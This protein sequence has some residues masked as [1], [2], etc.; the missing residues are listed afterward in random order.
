M[1]AALP[2]R[3]VRL[4]AVLATLVVSASYAYAQFGGG[5]FRGGFLVGEQGDP[6]EIMAGPRE[7]ADFTACH[8]L[9]TSVRREANGAGWRTDYPW[10]ERHLLLRLSELTKT[11]VSWLS[12]NVPHSWLVALTDDAL[13][14]CSYVTASDVG[15]IELSPEEAARLR[16]Y[17]EK[18]GFLWVDDFWGEAAW[19]QWASELGKAMPPDEFPIEEVALSD[20]IFHV[21]TEVTAVP[22]VPSIR[23]WRGSGGGTSE[24]GA[25]SAVPRLK[26]I[27][28]THQRIVVV[29]T[30]NTDMSDSFE[31]EGEDPRFF[32]QFSPNGYA[33]GINVLLY[34]LTH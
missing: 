18:G 23:F 29:M 15:T 27:R 4:F 12:K 11:R 24:R 31:R 25:E 20:P 22:Q 16:L 7:D 2:R 13:F 21:M 9:Y 33:L 10:G 28:D 19:E 8:M 30:H 1:R 17:L 32:A 6:A 14:Q 5:R 3:S 34:S 26:A